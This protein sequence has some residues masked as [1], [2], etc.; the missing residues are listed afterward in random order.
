MIVDREWLVLDSTLHI[1]GVFVPKFAS[2]SWDFLPKNSTGKLVLDWRGLKG[3]SV[4][5]KEMAI[6]SL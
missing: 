4:L 6:P 5:D 3:R 1:V 2:P